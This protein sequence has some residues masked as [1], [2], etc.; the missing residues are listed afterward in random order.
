[1][2]DREK[3]REYD[4]AQSNL[5]DLVAYYSEVVYEEEQKAIPDLAKTTQWQDEKESL[6]LLLEALDVEDPA[7]IAKVNATYGPILRALN[8]KE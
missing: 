7:G 4:F 3:W 8:A 5:L 2:S 6:R 1:M